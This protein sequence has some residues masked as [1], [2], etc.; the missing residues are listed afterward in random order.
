MNLYM[1]SGTVQEQAVNW[2]PDDPN[3]LAVQ[4]PGVL[5]VVAMSVSI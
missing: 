3:R 2:N 1:G 5:L 4:L